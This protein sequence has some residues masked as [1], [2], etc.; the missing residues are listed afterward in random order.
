MFL[1]QYKEA[2][3]LMLRPMGFDNKWDDALKYFLET[4]DAAGALDRIPKSEKLSVLKGQILL[5]IKHFGC[6][7]EGCLKALKALNP[8]HKSI[9][10]QAYV[11]LFWNE[12]IS[13]RIENR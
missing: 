11:N 7:D 6:N 1:G 13:K 4:E 2:V 9:Y 8:I 10:P 5:S 12:I 3:K